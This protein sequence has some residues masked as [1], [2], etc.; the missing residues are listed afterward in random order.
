VF[1]VRAVRFTNYYI[2][3]DYDPRFNLATVFSSARMRVTYTTKELT[4]YLLISRYLFLVASLITTGL[5]ALHCYRAWSNNK[6]AP[7][8]RATLVLALAVTCFNDPFFAIYIFN[9]N[10]ASSFF[11]AFFLSVFAI[12]LL[13]YWMHMVYGVA[14]DRQE[15]GALVRG[16]L[17]VMLVVSL[18]GSHLAYQLLTSTMPFILQVESNLAVKVMFIFNLLTLI[19]VTIYLAFY[20]VKA[21][22]KSTP[23]L[24]RDKVF[25]GLTVP[26]YTLSLIAGITLALSFYRYG[27]WSITVLFWGNL[28]V[29]VYEYMYTQA[30]PSEADQEVKDGPQ[31]EENYLDFESNKDPAD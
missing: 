21:F 27:K 22:T 25:L 5:Y 15:G 16:V 31:A 24:Y 4:D 2:Q 20:F 23:L 17:C 3:V 9:P 18:F 10:S 8:Q 6:L 13:A 11:S 1:F 26:F 12:T 29:W 14:C 28:L 19:A 7:E 30:A